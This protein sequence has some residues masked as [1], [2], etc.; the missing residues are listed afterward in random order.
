MEGSTLFNNTSREALNKAAPR[1]ASRRGR[2]VQLLGERGPSTIF[3]IAAAM[4][5]HDHQI[6]GRF[7]ELERD[8]LIRKTGRRREKPETGCEAEV[9]QLADAPT[10][11]DLGTALNHPD[12]LQIGDIG[13]FDRV[14][15][16]SHEGIGGVPYARQ[17]NEGGVPRLLYRV[18]LIECDGCGKPLHL[19]AQGGVK[20]YRCPTPGCNRSW[21]LMLVKEPGR[22]EMLAM[23]MTHL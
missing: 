6:S 12:S 16:T 1:F 15:W 21:K 22:A 19:A 4:E 18:C 14:P 2:I 9:Y 17:S 7:G 8:G 11:I 5:L 10:P 13:I 23:V 3:E 20:F